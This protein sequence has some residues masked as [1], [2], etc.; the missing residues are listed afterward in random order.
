MSLLI[1]CRH[2]VESAVGLFANAFESVSRL[3]AICPIT[4]VAP[5][6]FFPCILY[7]RPTVLAIRRFDDEPI[8]TAFQ[9]RSFGLDR[10]SSLYDDWLI[11]ASSVSLLP[12]FS[13]P[14]ASYSLELPTAPALALFNIS[15]AICFAL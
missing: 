10:T 12:L 9:F 4:S 14:F 2:T 3:L 11:M 13:R 7:P 8:S 6:S 1:S 15:L 5:S